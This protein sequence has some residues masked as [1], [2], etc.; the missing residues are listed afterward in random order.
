MP[1][2]YSALAIYSP[3]AEKRENSPSTLSLQPVGYN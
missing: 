3:K 1:I 2:V